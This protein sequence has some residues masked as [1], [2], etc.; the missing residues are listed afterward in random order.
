[1]AFVLFIK[2]IVIKY[3]QNLNKKSCVIAL[4]KFDLLN[5]QFRHTKIQEFMIH[6]SIQ[7]VQKILTSAESCIK[8]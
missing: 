6:Y 1:M 2:E 3:H 5:E 7:F 4:S 8:K